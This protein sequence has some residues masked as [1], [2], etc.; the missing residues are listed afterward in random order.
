MPIRPVLAT[1]TQVATTSN[2]SIFGEQQRP[3]PSCVV[4]NKFPVIVIDHINDAGMVRSSQWAEQHARPWVAILQRSSTPLT[5]AE[6]PTAVAT[7]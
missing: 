5:P 6:A 2:N 1:E 4:A 7:A 3:A